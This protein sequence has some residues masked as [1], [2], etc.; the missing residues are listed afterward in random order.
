[1]VSDISVLGK[2]TKGGGAK[3]QN[4]HKFFNDP[5]T[6]TKLVLNCFLIVKY[7]LHIML[8]EICFSAKNF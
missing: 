2:C 5:H 3:D 6:V 7:Y 4:F 1:M 8:L